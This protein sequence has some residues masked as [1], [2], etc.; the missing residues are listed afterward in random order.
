MAA[1]GPEFRNHIKLDVVAHTY[2][3]ITSLVI[4]EAMIRD[5][6]TF[7]FSY[8]SFCPNSVVHTYRHMWSHSQK[9]G[10]PTSVYLPIKRNGFPSSAAF[11]HH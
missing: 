9:P 10:E 7:P 11:N 3:P 2:N 5:S 6:Q 4:W 8:S 1:Q